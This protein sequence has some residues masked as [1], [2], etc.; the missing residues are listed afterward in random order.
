[1]YPCEE[2]FF[3]KVQNELKRLGEGY[4]TVQIKQES[5]WFTFNFAVFI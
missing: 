5:D 1:M 3:Q 4:K 2:K